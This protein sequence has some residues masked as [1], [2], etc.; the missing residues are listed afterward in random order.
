MVLSRLLPAWLDPW[1]HDD[2]RIVT[3]LQAEHIWARLQANGRIKAT[4]SDD[5]H[6]LVVARGGRYLGGYIRT[7]GTVTSHGSGTEL[8]VT[9]RRPT[10]SK[11]I[12]GAFAA[13]AVLLLVNG[14]VP[15]IVQHGPFAIWSWSSLTFLIGPAS[16]ALV[17]ALNHSSAKADVRELKAI[18]GS[19]MTQ[20]PQWLWK[21]LPK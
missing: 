2:S 13:L 5:G 8:T 21:T 17:L 10:A 16:L 15:T 20:P 4:L 9:F 19:T 1:W 3:P 14:A 11:W 12:M 7:V 18:I 6:E